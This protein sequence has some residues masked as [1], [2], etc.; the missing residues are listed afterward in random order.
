MIDILREWS[1]EWYAFLTQLGVVMAEPV[2]SLSEQWNIPVITAL[3]LGLVAATSPCQLTTNASA[4]AYISRNLNDR[5]ETLGQTFSFVGGKILVYMLIGGTAIYLGMQMTSAYTT[6]PVILF[7]RKAIG[8]LL[9]LAGLYFLGYLRFR[10][11]VGNRM[12]EWLKSKIPRSGKWGAFGLG[13]AFAL[14]FCPTLLWL[15]FGLLIP[16]GLKTTGGVFLPAIF[17]FG[18]A[19]P[20]LFFALILA[21]STDLLKKKYLKGVRSMNRVA[22][23]IAA[24][25]FILAGIN[26]TFVYW[27]L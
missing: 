24:I 21:D 8:P 11:S 26:D 4:L 13:S 6:V 2:L 18:T 19:I 14:A 16:L 9:I 22:T 1:L 10:V 25:I 12:S 3:L 7:V 27:F 20:V 15:F 5:K 17:A 23:K